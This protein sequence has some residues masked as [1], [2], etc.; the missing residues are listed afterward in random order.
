MGFG[1]PSLRYK[2]APCPNQAPLN[3]R[4]FGQCFKSHSFGRNPQLY[5]QLGA[6]DPPI[7]SHLQQYTPKLPGLSDAWCCRKLDGEVPGAAVALAAHG[8]SVVDQVGQQKRA[9]LTG[10]GRNEP[11]GAGAASAMQAALH[12]QWRRYRQRDTC[13]VFHP[14]NLEFSDAPPVR[15][16]EKANTKNVTALARVWPRTC[17]QPAF[18][19]QGK[20]PQDTK[21]EQEALVVSE[22]PQLLAEKPH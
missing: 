6:Q 10:R 12:S 8:N 22:T 11:S 4:G 9:G 15:Q 2:Q 1:V 7:C 13:F 18:L 19:I 20:F 17:T 21:I 3:R 5:C 16:P 14:S